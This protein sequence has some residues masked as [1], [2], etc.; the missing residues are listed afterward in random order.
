MRKIA[1][2]MA[3][4]ATAFSAEAQESKFYLGG[5]LGLA[6]GGEMDLQVTPAATA[7]SQ[8]RLV[9]DHDTGFSG[10]L[11]VGYDF[12]PIRVEAEGTGLAAGIK[13]VDSDWSHSSGLAVGDQA[14]DGDVR[15]RGALANVIVDF[16]RRG[17]YSFFVG[18]GAGASRIKADMALGQN[19]FVLLDDSNDG[20]KASWQLIAGARKSF[21]DRLEGHIRYRYMDVGDVELVGF[22]GR[23]MEGRLTTHLV[24]AG[25][26]YRFR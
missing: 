5:D 20:W 16:G 13:G 23:V 12:G 21:S 15:A 1:L 2:M 9:T 11:L 26:T 17:D 6:T 14:A 8:G 24:S 4:A 7:G 22:G 19:D 18:A 25:V 10:S 3:L